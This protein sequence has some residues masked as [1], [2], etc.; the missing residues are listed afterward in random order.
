[1]SA[2]TAAPS[3]ST[4]SPVLTVSDPARRNAFTLDLSAKLARAVRA[5]VDDERVGAI[6]I[7][8]EPPAFCAGGGLSELGRSDPRRACGG[9]TP[10]SW[11]SPTARCRRSPR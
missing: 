11:P 7:T 1:M 8:G 9:S 10:A 6:V 3:A 5:C 4:R 2:E